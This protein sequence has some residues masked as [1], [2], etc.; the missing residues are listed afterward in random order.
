MLDEMMNDESLSDI[1]HD[2]QLDLVRQIWQ[3]TLALEQYVVTLREKVNRLSS[4]A[5]NLPYPDVESDFRVRFFS[6]VSTRKMDDH[7]KI[8]GLD[9]C[10]IYL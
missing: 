9:A 7:V 10:G 3:Y 8:L 1:D 4:H 5:S 6:G 2:L